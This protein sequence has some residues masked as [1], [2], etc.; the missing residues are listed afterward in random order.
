M[1]H[2]GY[3]IRQEEEPA[4]HLAEGNGAATMYAAGRGATLPAVERR[5]RPS[6]GHSRPSR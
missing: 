5:C 6:W 4:R 1:E 3:P 2:F